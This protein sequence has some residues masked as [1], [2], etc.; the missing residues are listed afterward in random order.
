MFRSHHLHPNASCESK[1]VKDRQLLHQNALQNAKSP[2]RN[3][4]SE[5]ENRRYGSVPKLII[6]KAKKDLLE[7][8]K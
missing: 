6:N 1:W 8:G 2:V 3:M 7:E 4:F 5:S